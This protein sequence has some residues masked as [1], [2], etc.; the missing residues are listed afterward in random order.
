MNAETEN[1]TEL[2]T[3]VDTEFEPP[4]EAE[5]GLAA[6][7][8]AGACADGGAGIDADER[9]IV[10]DAI[11]R[12]STVTR[13][14][15]MITGVLFIASG[16]WWAGIIVIVVTTF[17]LPRVAV[18]SYARKRGVQLNVP[19]A[20]EVERTSLTGLLIG[21]VFLPVVCGLAG[22]EMALGHPLLP[23]SWTTPMG[24]DPD[25]YVIL[26][27]AVGALAITV[28]WFVR[29]LTDSRQTSGA[30]DSQKGSG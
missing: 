2:A 1:G 26:P 27:L 28:I 21:V 7:A 14:I 12:G 10:G 24:D 18:Q 22:A 20:A 15:A 30:H 9:R 4:I 3:S 29:R 5:N 11:A 25:P 13:W 8:D 19:S 23:W 16:L 17:D 6:G